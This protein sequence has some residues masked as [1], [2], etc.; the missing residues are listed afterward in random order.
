MGFSV[1]KLPTIVPNCIR[2][3]TDWYNNSLQHHEGKSGP[4]AVPDSVKQ[5]GDPDKLRHSHCG[6]SVTAQLGKQ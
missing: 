6:D 1:K 5:T 4:A 2:P 3:N